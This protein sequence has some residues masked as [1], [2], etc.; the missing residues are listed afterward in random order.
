MYVTSSVW[1]VVNAK[2]LLV[3]ACLLGFNALNVKPMAHSK[4]CGS[5][6]YFLLKVWVASLSLAR[7]ALFL[8]N[9]LKM[10]FVSRCLLVMVVYLVA[11]SEGNN[12]KSLTAAA[13][14]TKRE[15]DYIIRFFKDWSLSRSRIAYGAKFEFESANKIY[16]R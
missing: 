12:L 10:S 9:Q 13:V 4:C 14:F 7:L 3:L 16:V 8:M 15:I 1:W 6:H 2:M 5:E 11:R